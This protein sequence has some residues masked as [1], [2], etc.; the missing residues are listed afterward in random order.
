[1]TRDLKEAQKDPEIPALF[2]D[3]CKR[4]SNSNFSMIQILSLGNL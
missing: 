4:K 2:D 1:L 3:K